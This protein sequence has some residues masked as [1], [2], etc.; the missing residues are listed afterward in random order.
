VAITLANANAESNSVFEPRLAA[1]YE[2]SPDTTLR[3]SYGTYARPPNASWVQYGTLQQDLATPLVQKFIAYGFNSPQH[4][5]LPDVS[6]N[7]DVSWEQRL[8]GSDVSFKLTPY[9]RGTMGQFENILLDNNGNQSGVNVG[10]ERSLG[11][12]LALQKGNFTSDG[13]S[14]LL[15]V[16]YNHSRFRY[17]KFASGCNVLGSSP[18]P[19]VVDFVPHGTSTTL[20]TMS[21]EC[22]TP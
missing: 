13:V 4:H 2:L 14:A 1:T 20:R 18:R 12:E 3:A 19:A 21:T 5:L 9:Y 17:A 6:H 15:S 11:V 16:T 10:S 7:V 8:A 22:S